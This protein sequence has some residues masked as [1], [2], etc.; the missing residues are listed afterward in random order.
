MDMIKLLLDEMLAVIKGLDLRPAFIGAIPG[1]EEEKYS[2][3]A[4]F[5]LD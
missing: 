5:D 2:D 3:D 1:E 4:S